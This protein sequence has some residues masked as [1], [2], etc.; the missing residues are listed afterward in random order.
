MIIV[1]FAVDC[2]VAVGIAQADLPTFTGQRQ[3]LACSDV[4]PVVGSG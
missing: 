4:L 3:L 1:I 2:A